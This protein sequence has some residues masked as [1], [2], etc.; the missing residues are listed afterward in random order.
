[1]LK[2]NLKQPDELNRDSGGTGYPNHRVLIGNENLFNIAL[3]NDITHG[4]SP[5]ASHH[6]T[7]VT[8]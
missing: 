6:R 1:M 4:C 5:V 8:A 7:K 2:F 3:S